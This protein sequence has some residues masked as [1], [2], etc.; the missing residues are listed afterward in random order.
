MVD[1]KRNTW[2]AKIK[3]TF[4][5][6]FPVAKNRTGKCIDCG[7]CCKLPNVCAF[8]RFKS[9]GKSYCSIRGIRPLNCRRY[10]RKE[11]EFVTKDTCG[12]R[13]E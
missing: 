5:S 12:F 7:E 2:S 8:L 11:S 4:T 10:P 3:R 1:K 6:P 13:F 9:E